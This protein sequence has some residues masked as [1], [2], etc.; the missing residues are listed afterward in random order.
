M[1]PMTALVLAF[2]LLALFSIA[3]A[4]II[5]LIC[6]VREDNVEKAEQ[7]KSNTVLVTSADTALGL[8]LCTHL[9][10]KGCRVV[11]GMR[12]G[13][14]SLPAKLL[15]GWLKMREFTEA[16]VSGTIIPMLLDVTKDDVLREATETMGSHLSVGEQ[17]IAAVINTSGTFYRGRIESQELY[18]MEQM[19][20]TNIL[21]SLRIAKA[22]VDFLRPTRGRL[23]YLGAASGGQ[24]DGLIA[25]NVSRVATD[26]C[27]QELRRELQPFGVSVVCLDTCGLHAETLY[28]PP[29]AQISSGAPT[30]YTAN[31]L[32][33]SALHV[34]ERALWDQAPHERYSLLA[35]NK[36]Q[37]ALP[38]R[39]SIRLTNKSSDVNN[40]NVKKP[41]EHHNKGEVQRV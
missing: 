35:S 14:D 40:T 7:V 29:T 39:S 11:A 8:Q 20:K 1:E 23:I 38:C 16:P 24:G 13:V 26:K 3:G 21:G 10:S 4:L 25:Y 31:V 6:K 41:M 36:Y 32:S 9:A 37:F 18:Q 22:F 19:F 33:P 27:V 34:V 5:Y 28:K 12:E 2:Q 15:V 30:T 17:G